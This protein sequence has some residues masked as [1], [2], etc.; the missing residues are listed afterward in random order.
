[1]H[2]DEIFD[3]TFFVAA[4]LTALTTSAFAQRPRR[5]L[6]ADAG[7]GLRLRQGRQTLSYKMGTNNA[8][9]C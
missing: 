2:D 9:C 5:A 4:A 1:M 7:H 3:Q 8:G 6:G